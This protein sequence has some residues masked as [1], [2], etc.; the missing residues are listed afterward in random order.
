MR[1]RFHPFQCSAVIKSMKDMDPCAIHMCCWIVDGANA[2]DA[3]TA[4]RP[5]LALPAPEGAAS[6]GNLT[7]GAVADVA[8][9]TD[10]ASK[11]R[12][13]P[14]T[15]A[16]LRAELLS[17]GA[18]DVSEVTAEDWSGLSSWGLLKQFERRRLLK[19]IARRRRGT[20]LLQTLAAR[21]S[22]QWARR[23]GCTFGARVLRRW[24]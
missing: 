19:C 22:G 24:A 17:A 1:N 15:T 12:L 3:K 8:G 23:A 10:L 2:A 9:L 20:V 14:E 5:P 7:G 11:A 21:A 4:L 18:V 16:A 13:P 6:S